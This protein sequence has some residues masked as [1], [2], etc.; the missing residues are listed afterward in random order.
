[1][2]YDPYHDE[3]PDASRK[4]VPCDHIWRASNLHLC[5]SDMRTPA[6][7]GADLGGIGG[8]SLVVSHHF[9]GT[10]L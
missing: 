1:M 5:Q 4:F 2:R 3:L 8:G 9:L 10:G 7:P 6:H